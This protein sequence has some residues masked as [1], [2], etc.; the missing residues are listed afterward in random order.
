MSGGGDGGTSYQS[1]TN[2]NNQ[3]TGPNPTIGPKLESILGDFWSWY[4]NNGNAP[5][6]YPGTTVAP[7][8]VASQSAVTSLFNRGAN[9]WQGR[10]GALGAINDTIG[11]KY[12]DINNNK[13]FSGAL[14]AAF[15]PQ[16]ENLM[17]NVLPG[18]D[19]KFSGSGRTAGGAHFDTT[20]RGVQDLNRAQS[21]AAAKAALAA[22]TGERGNQM[23]AIGMLPSF[24]AA[25]YQDLAAMQQAGAIKDAETQ[26]IINADVARYN[27]A[28]TAQPEWLTRMAQMIQG[29][30]PGGYSSG[31]GTSSGYSQQPG[32]GT[33]WL[34]TGM[35]LAGLGL[36]AYTAFSDARLKDVVGRVGQ[37]DE[38]LPLYL[39][40][41]KGDDQPRIG[42]MAQEVA[43]VKPDAVKRH[44][45]GFL[46]VDYSKL[47]PVGGL[48]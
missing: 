46:Q 30:Y 5:A 39:Y 21:E 19:S 45:S 17:N 47:A 24:Q 40:K 6:Y 4:A 29:I 3:T 10:Q 1:S 15:A 12:L 33:S 37:T 42:P 14:S 7:S 26:G 23:N 35:E 2:S 28:K 8:S 36:Q 32:G 22:Y 27:Y 18:I 13:Y 25:D 31:S 41:Y 43:Q 20:M 48:L 34:G 44:D 11:G 16:T 9:G 38:G